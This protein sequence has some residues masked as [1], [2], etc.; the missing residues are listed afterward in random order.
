[1]VS[2]GE[3]EREGSVSSTLFSQPMRVFIALNSM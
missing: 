1:M 2:S 3:S